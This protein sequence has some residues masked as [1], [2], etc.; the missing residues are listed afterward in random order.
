VDVMVIGKAGLADL[1][2][3]LRKAEQRL[4]R[5]VKATVYSPEEF[6]EKVK[7]HDHFLAMVLKGRKHFVR[8]GQSDL[9]EI[10]GK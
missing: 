7:S 8:G 5:E 3:A 10:V 9:D 1:S 2:S 4:G 6:R